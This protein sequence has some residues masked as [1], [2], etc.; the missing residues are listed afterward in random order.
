M[1]ESCHSQKWLYWKKQVKELN[2][3]NDESVTGL[4]RETPNT[5]NGGQEKVC[6]FSA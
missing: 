1:N 5:V 4:N 6:L 2:K 3:M